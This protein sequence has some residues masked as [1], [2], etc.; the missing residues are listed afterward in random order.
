MYRACAHLL[1]TD[2]CHGD[3]WG[4]GHGALYGDSDVTCHLRYVSLVGSG[5][6]GDQT[7]WN[8][9]L[10]DSLRETRELVNLTKLGEF[11]RSRAD[12]IC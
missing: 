7:T 2:G 4:G 5:S 6:R 10:M 12:L 11:L 1:T 8:G 3:G 9:R